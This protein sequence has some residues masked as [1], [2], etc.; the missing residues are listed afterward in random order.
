MFKTLVKINLVIIS[1]GYLCKQALKIKFNS[2]QHMLASMVHCYIFN[3]HSSTIVV[4]STTTIQVSQLL[5]GSVG[6]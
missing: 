6:R 3:L 1:A 4:P 5:G 2:I